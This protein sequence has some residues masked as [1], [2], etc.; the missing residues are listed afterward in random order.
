MDLHSPKHV[1][2]LCE[3]KIMTRMHLVGFNCYRQNKN[4][5]KKQ[6]KKQ[7]KYI[8]KEKRKKEIMA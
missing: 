4:S 5:I 6:G 1:E 8:N 7:I 3:I 2:D